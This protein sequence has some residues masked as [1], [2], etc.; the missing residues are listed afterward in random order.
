[1]EHLLFCPGDSA[2]SGI[3]SVWNCQRNKFCSIGTDMGGVQIRAGQWALAM[4]RPQELRRTRA[5]VSSCWSH[6]THR[7]PW[8]PVMPSWIS[9]LPPSRCIKCGSADLLR[10]PG[11]PPPTAPSL[12][13]QGFSPSTYRLERP[14]PG[15]ALRKA[16]LF[17]KSSQKGFSEEVIFK[18]DFEEWVGIYQGEK[19]P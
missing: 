7:Q 18:L 15:K 9:R 12:G 13:P 8:G 10:L 4:G 17:C 16:L 2:L 14:R 3:H 11:H 1:M 6:V 5:S 19:P